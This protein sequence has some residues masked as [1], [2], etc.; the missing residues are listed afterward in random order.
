M[1]N[2]EDKTSIE[3]APRLK[4]P[5]KQHLIRTTFRI[6]QQGHDAI[7]NVSKIYGMKN[8]DVFDMASSLV[9]E[10]NKKGMDLSSVKDIS[11]ISIRKTYLI[12]K[13]SLSRLR[14]L[15]GEMKTSRDLLIDKLVT[16]LK[17]LLDK[18]SDERNI[19]YRNALK[20]I[21]SPFLGQTEKLEKQL[22]IKLGEDDP[23]T[24][25]FGI[26]ILLI[27]NLSMA[28]EKNINKGV[29]IDPDDYS[30]NS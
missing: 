27:K 10:F 14:K 29:P 26:I 11:G 23:I 24:S 1:G 28:I 19:K 17:T 5:Y 22:K 7:T 9:Q 18:E 6:S 4:L 13:I 3:K 8:A 30:Q 12:N 15:A 21:I 2:R 20:E 16:T 25:R